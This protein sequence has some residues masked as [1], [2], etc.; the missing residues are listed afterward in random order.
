M[1]PVPAIHIMLPI[2]EGSS[3]FRQYQMQTRAAH[4]ENE[5]KHLTA[6]SSELGAELA[7]G[8]LRVL[9]ILVYRGI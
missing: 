1:S 6:G 5:L 3:D 8:R 7:K 9:F 2:L 4:L